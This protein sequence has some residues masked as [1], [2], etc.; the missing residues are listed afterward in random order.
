[1]K[2]KTMK[3]ETMKGKT[4]KRYTFRRGVHDVAPLCGL[5]L[6]CV[7]P[8]VAYMPWAPPKGGVRYIGPPEGGRTYMADYG[9]RELH[10]V[11]SGLRIAAASG[12]CSRPCP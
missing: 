4:A 7:V 10:V 8:C 6:W 1:M 11:G 3:C 2:S 9:E 5:A 12:Q